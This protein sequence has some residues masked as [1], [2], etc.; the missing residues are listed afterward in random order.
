M[1][2]DYFWIINLSRLVCFGNDNFEQN[3]KIPISWCEKVWN[4]FSS[5]NIL[6][7]KSDVLKCYSVTKEIFDIHTFSIK[8]VC[9]F[10][11]TWI[12]TW[13][14]PSNGFRLL[15]TKIFVI[16]SNFPFSIFFPH[17]FGWTP[18]FPLFLQLF[19]SFP[20]LRQPSKPHV[21][22]ICL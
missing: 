22:V 10:G 8:F 16:R 5:S 19:P 14:N 7:Y 12:C 3:W 2:I 21:F 6:N 13:Q 11:G 17:F 1:R 9:S 20:L 4:I 15:I 18:F